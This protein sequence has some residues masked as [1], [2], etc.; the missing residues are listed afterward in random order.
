MI[1]RDDNDRW[2]W[3]ETHD[4]NTY[5]LGYLVGQTVLDIGAHIGSFAMLA[6]EHGARRVVCIEPCAANAR[7]LRENLAFW[8]QRVEII[9]KAVVG[10][11]QP[12]GTTTLW[13]CPLKKGNAAAG[14]SGHSIAWRDSKEVSTETVATIPFSHVM[15]PWFDL[16]K[17][18]CEGSEYAIIRSPSFKD[19]RSMV[20]EF[21]PITSHAPAD[22][23]RWLAE[24]GF[25]EEKWVEA[26][27]PCGDKNYWLYKGV[28]A[29]MKSSSACPAQAWYT[30][31]MSPGSPQNATR[32]IE[33]SPATAAPT[34]IP[35]GSPG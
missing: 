34:L 12:V 16:V 2:I 3:R 9:Q 6:L 25:I 11:N 21:H 15:K 23:R 20:A 4:E 13:H 26:V 19:V 29:C 32:C 17:L 8:G 1:L 14:G 33:P 22:A 31:P 27:L 28:Q 24:L 5:G 18:D 7:L 10:D 30:T 35:A